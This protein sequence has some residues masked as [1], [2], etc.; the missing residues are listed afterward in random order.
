MAAADLIP[1]DRILPLLSRRWAVTWDLQ[2]ALAEF[3]P[4]VVMAKLKQLKRRGLI[5]G[6]DCGCR[7]DWHLIDPIARIP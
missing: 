4:K 7:G 3:P 2:G 1:D 5:D 6:C